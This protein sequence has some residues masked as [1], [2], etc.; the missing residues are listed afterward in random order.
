MLA[1]S[2]VIFASS[3]TIFQGRRQS[4]E[5]SQA[6]YD[7]QSQFQSYST[8]VSTANLPSG[9]TP[10]LCAVS[11]ALVNGKVHPYLTAT[12]QTNDSVSNQNCLYLGR[13]IQV[14]PNTASIYTYPVLG[15]RTVYNGTIDTGDFP[16]TSSQANP[17]PALDVN[18][19]F[20]LVGTYNLLNGV[21]V[22]SA[23]LAGSPTETDYLG[24][25]TSLQNSNTNGS[26]INA[27]ARNVTFAPTDV[28]S[29]N[30]RNCIEE[31][32]CGSPTSLSSRWILCVQN[33]AGN[34]QAG[35]SLKSSPTGLVMTLNMDNCT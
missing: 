33:N 35:L 27:F 6:M 34:K 11:S 7:L 22:V 4:T 26:D 13:A 19:N 5:F 29:T 2:G 31:A 21:K 20:L 1:V 3:V 10:Y 16:S 9:A 14:V 18:G 25:Y 28:Q 23:K 15:L 12:T 32:G 8:Q 30:L 24:V 17:E